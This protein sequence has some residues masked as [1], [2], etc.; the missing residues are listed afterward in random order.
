MKKLVFLFL[1]SI[2]MINVATANTSEYYVDDA[3]LSEMFNSATEM[4][5]PSLAD[6]DMTANANATTVS[7]KKAG[8]AFIL[9]WFLG[10]IG[11]HRHYLGTS[12]NM[13]AVYTFTCCGILGIVPTIDFWV[14]LIDGVING[15]I[16]GYVDNEKFFMW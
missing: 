6:F 5:A 10:G 7:E 14:L 2:G 4:A 12:S 11:V 16:D 9:C 15:N 8:I 13:W 1:L 3:S